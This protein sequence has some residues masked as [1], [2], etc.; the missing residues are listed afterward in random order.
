MRCS[1]RSVVFSLALTTASPPPRTPRRII[2]TARCGSSSRSRPAAATTWS[3]AWSRTSS[4]TSSASRS[5]STI[6]AAPAACIGTESAAKAAPDGYTLLVISIAHAVN[7]WLYKLNYDPIKDFVPIS[8]TGD[9]TERARGPS[10]SAGAQRQ[11]ADRARQAEAGRAVLCLRRHRQL[12]ASRRRAVQAD[13][14]RRH[15]ARALQGRR[16][17]D[18]GRDR[19]PRQGHVLLAGADDAQHQVRASCARSASAAPSAARSCP[20]CRPSTRPACPAT[21]RTNWWGIVAPAG[22]PQPIVDKVH[23]AI[24]AGAQLARDQEIFRQ[25]GRGAGAI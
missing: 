18:A 1:I 7:P 16:T 22:T 17:G 14:R 21:R 12:P 24:A 5:S 10:R 6:A 19:R 25:R 23:D 13:G 11:G 2:R 4:A 3:A 8:I 15:R 20:T 9:R